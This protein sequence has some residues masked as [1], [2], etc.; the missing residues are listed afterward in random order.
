MTAQIAWRCDDCKGEL[1]TIYSNDTGFYIQCK[2]CGL[3]CF[4]GYSGQKVWDDGR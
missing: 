3:G 4:Y 2:N 1:K